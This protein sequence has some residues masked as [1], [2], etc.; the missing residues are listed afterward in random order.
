MCYLLLR[1]SY[2]QRGKCV[3]CCYCLVIGSAVSVLSV[4]II[5][6]WLLAARKV[7]YLLLSLR[8]GYWQRGKCVICCY[9]YGLVIGSA[10]SVLSVVIITVWLLAVRKVCYLLL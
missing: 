4:V 2:W 1:F 6:V 5:T 8:F 7:C 9:N 10:E 3:I